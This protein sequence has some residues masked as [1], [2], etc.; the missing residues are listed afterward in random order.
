M[1]AVRQL[2][3]IKG[4][5]KSGGLSL[6]QRVRRERWMYLFILPG[7]LY[8]LIFN[9][10]PLIGN[11][12]AFQNYSPFLGFRESPWVGLENFERLF[13]DPDFKTALVN[14]IQIEL[15][16][17]IFAFPAP[18]MLALLLNSLISEGVKRSI[19]SVVYLPHFLSWVIIIALWQQ[20]LGGDGIFNGYLRNQGLDTVNIMSNPEIFKPLMVVQAIW[21]DVG[22]GTIIFLAALTKIDTQ[23]YEAAVIDGAGGWRRLRD[24]TLPGI[25]SVVVLLLILRLGSMFTVGFEQYFLQRNAVGADA[26][27]VLDTFVYFRGI[28]GGDWGFATAV[29]LVRSVVGLMLIA[30]ANW[31]AQRFGEEG[32]F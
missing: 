18:L 26:A 7:L 2:T 22:W 15:L 10:V 12:V 4:Y 17:I 32:I 1:A 29:G 25:R 14:T 23:L 19:Q 9:Y 21:K 5:E 16:Q 13:T 3:S 31:L 6:W 24:V 27:E 20:V 11:I 8:F 30:T 28:Q